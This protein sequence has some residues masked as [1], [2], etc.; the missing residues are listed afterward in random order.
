[1]Q[2]TSDKTILRK[3]SEQKKLF[4]FLKQKQNN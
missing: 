4:E 2:Q 3:V 1:M